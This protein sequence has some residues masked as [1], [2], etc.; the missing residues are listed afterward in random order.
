MTAWQRLGIEP[1]DNQREIK[2]A[3]AKQL[4]L[5]DQ[6]TQPEEFIRLR[7]ALETAQFEA[8]Y[9]FYEDD[10]VNDIF[11]PDLEKY[12]SENSEVSPNADE[13][14]LEE[15]LKNL[16]HH[17]STQDINFDI[18]NELLQFHHQIQNI[19]D[20]NTSI[21]YSN[22][23]QNLLKQY[24]LDDFLYIFSDHQPQTNIALAPYN[25]EAITSQTV[26]ELPLEAD[27]SI[28]AEPIFIT[29]NEVTDSL[30]N[31]DIS[32]STFEKFK[33][34]LNQQFDIPLHQ[35]IQIKDQLIAPLAEID[36]NNLQP[37]YFRFLELWHES[38]PDDIH[39]YDQSYYSSLLQEK[40]ND[41]LSKHS[42]LKQ[43]KPEQYLALQ[44]LTGEQK[45]QPFKMINLQNHLHKI[46]TNHTTTEILNQLQISST[47]NNPN[48]V[49]LKSLSEI[50]KF[51][52]INLIFSIG[53]FYFSSLLL[54]ITPKAGIVI[55][56]SLVTI[57]LFI[58][59]LQPIL[60]AK[61]LGRPDQ[62]ETLIRLSKIWFLSGFILCIA[63]PW[64]AESLHQ[65]LSY[66]W[67]VF[68]VLLI[69][70]L[71]LNAAPHH[72][73][74]LQ[75]ADSQFD[76]WI[77][78]LGLIA[79]CIGFFFA[80]LSLAKPDHSWLAV[81]SLI[82]ISLLL[83]PDSFRPLFSIFGYNKENDNLTEN[84]IYFKSIM[85]ILFRLTWIL[86]IGYFL[87]SE[88]NKP[89]IYAS[90]LILTSL[91]FVGMSTKKISQLIRYL[92]FTATFFTIIILF[93]G[94]DAVKYFLAKI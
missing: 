89:F 25:D 34:L 33:Y 62:E 42:I 91:L 68:S 81:Y 63:T 43:L 13:L 87:I 21:T 10:E 85:I 92:A 75:S 57:A 31:K 6:D 54:E 84:Q 16:E 70:A 72:N 18:R 61:I 94:L 23:V 5:I 11:E 88:N 39:Q 93:I 79:I 55:C 32:D 26:Q 15:S 41:Y 28:V 51:N 53:T 2:K 74:L 12:A 48:F 69:G 73:N 4:K 66:T 3:Y 8:A 59:I 77:I 50:K 14:Q 80:I 45:L 47:Q 27:H 52:L 29:L 38:Y 36:S 78:N 90:G 40:L 19:A 1:T 56:I 37:E 20:P 60:H 17:I 35:Q 46:Y 30:W 24:D 58:C 86:A 22:K 7:E 67:L 76:H 65:L 49:F 71:K 83:L 44:A 64:F 82:P 9:V